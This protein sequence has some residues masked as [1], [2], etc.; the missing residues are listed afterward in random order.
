LDS[1]VFGFAKKGLV[2]KMF[3]K[4][5]REIAAL[6]WTLGGTAMVLITLSGQTLNQGLWIVLFSFI[7]HMI[8]V[9]FT[10]DDNDK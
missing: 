4:F 1:V 6:A 10:K 9:L 3:K 7:L 5:R 8:G 2:K